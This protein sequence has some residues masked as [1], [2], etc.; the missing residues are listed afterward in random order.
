MP[1]P[2]VKVNLQLLPEVPPTAMKYTFGVEVV[3]VHNK[4]SPLVLEILFSPVS[5]I[6]KSSPALHTTPPA[7]VAPFSF[8][9]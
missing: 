6:I 5:S 8:N 4:A 2:D 9:M 3:K 1:T 7:I